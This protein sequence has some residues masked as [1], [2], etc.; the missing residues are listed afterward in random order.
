MKI[1]WLFLLLLVTLGMGCLVHYVPY[2]ADS[3]QRGYKITCGNKFERCESKA[4]DL[5]PDGFERVNS[6]HRS[7]LDT[8]NLLV[9]TDNEYTLDVVCDQPAESASGSSGPT[10]GLKAP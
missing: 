10:S 3:G 4:K 1:C 2:D 7:K 9:K 6:S 8:P 5:C